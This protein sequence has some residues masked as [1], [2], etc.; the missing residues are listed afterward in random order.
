MEEGKFTFNYIQAHAT[1]QLGRG[2]LGGLQKKIQKL[3]RFVVL[4]TQW[5]VIYCTLKALS[6]IYSGSGD[7]PCKAAGLTCK[8]GLPLAPSRPLARPKP[9]VCARMKTSLVQ[10]RRGR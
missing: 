4:Q 9:P 10:A 7:F 3:G 6:G 5:C 1:V 8:P 2:G